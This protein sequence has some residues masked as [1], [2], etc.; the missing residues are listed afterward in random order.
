MA[1][2]AVLDY[3]RGR[4][5]AFLVLPDP[6]SSSPEDTADHHD[7][8]RDEMV[9]TVVMTN[10]FGHALMVVPWTRQLDTALAR[11]A[12]H[13]PNA[14]RTGE[15]ELRS[16]MPEFD[17][18]SWPPLGLYLLMPTFIDREV[19]DREQVVFPAGRPGT[20]VCLRTEELFRDDPVVITALTA[21]S[22]SSEP[23]G[24]RRG[25]LWAVKPEPLGAER[26]T[27]AE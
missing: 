4:G 19:A 8:S 18:A 2:S 11:R 20:L 23:V 27:G 5:V 6:D 25:N 16:T 12:M 13:D 17:P 10:R 3:L 21:E 24:T 7:V 26:H 14:E 22:Q 15:A 1:V 9:R